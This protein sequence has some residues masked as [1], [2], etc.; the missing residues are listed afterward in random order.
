VNQLT[1]LEGNR[2]ARPEEMVPVLEMN[3]QE[4][5]DKNPCRSLDEEWIV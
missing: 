4:R 5:D 2:S 3:W 1:E